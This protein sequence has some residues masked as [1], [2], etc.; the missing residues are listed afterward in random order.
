MLDLRP[1]T[2]VLTHVLSAVRD[3]QLGAPT[4]CRDTTVGDLIDHVD[5]FCRTF[6]AA[7]NKTQRPDSQAPTPSAARLG[8]DWRDRIP[9]RLADLAQAWRDEAAWS[10]TTRAGGIDLP[11]DVA[12]LVAVDELVVHGW[13]IA[14]ATGQRYDCD[15]ALLAAAYGFVQHSVEQNP[16]GTPGLFGRPV[17]VPD[18]APLLERLIG[19]AGRDPGWSA[20]SR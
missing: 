6:T 11:A 9:A 17:P 12:G 3:D 8:D 14:V 5:G 4:P 7:A 20:A 2:D 15:Q 19:L 13:D 1:A 10:G 16:N 18:D